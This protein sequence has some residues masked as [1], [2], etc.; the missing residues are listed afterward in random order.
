MESLRF[1]AKSFEIEKN[2]RKKYLIIAI[3][4]FGVAKKIEYLIV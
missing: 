3:V 2:N 4:N 1:W